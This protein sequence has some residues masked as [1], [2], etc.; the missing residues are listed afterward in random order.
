M[1]KGNEGMTKLMTKLKESRPAPCRRPIARLLVSYDCSAVPVHAIL[2][3]PG[4]ST[5]Y[6]VRKAKFYYHA[7]NTHVMR[8]YGLFFILKCYPRVCI[9]V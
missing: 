2:E 9:T 3:N 8:E 5:K 6:V 4:D 7:A 1:R